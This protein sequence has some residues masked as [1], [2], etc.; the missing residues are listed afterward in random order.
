MDVEI[1][2]PHH[3][4]HK[5]GHG[6]LDKLLPLSA[7]LISIVSIGIA[8]HHGQVMQA[9]VQQNERLVQAN[10]LPFVQLAHSTAADDGTLRPSMLAMNSGV[11]PAH[12]RSVSIAVDGRPVQDLKSLLEA[13][14]GG[15][16]DVRMASS[17]LLHRMLQAGETIHY[18]F[19]MGEDAKTPVANAFI[20]AA[21][22]G[23]IVTTV[24]YC[25]VFEECWV[26]ASQGM[27]QPKRVE[28]CPIPKVQYRT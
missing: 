24:C 20:K 14:C 9:L 25:S 8:F 11:G 27:T 7:I 22:S 10:S 16:G 5:T 1:E 18:A 2:H 23:R 28:V 15:S 21:V 13:C 19:A 3:H 4:H 12:V 26:T 17:T 6:W